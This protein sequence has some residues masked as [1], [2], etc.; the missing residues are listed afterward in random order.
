MSNVKV[1]VGV[2]FCDDEKVR[3]ILVIIVLIEKEE[4]FC[5]LEWI[6]IKLF[7]IIDCIDYIK[8]ILCKN[9]LYLVCEEV[10]CFN[11][12]ECFN[13]GIVIFMILG[14]ICICCCLFC[15]VVYGKLLLLS[16]EEL[17]KL[18]IIIKEMVLKYVVI[19]LVDCDDLCDGGVQYFVDCIKVICEYSLVI[20]IEVLVL[21]FCG[22]MDCVLEIFKDVLLDVFNYNLEII[23]CLYCECCL[24]VNYQWLFDL[25]RKFKVQYFDVLIKFGLMMGMGE[26]QEE[27]VE[28]FKD[29]CVYD[30]EMFILGQY[31]QLSCY[32]FLVK[33]YVYLDEFNVFGDIVKVLGFIYV[34][35]G[36]MVCLSYYVDCQVVGEDVKQFVVVQ[37]E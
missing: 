20:K 13:Y 16:V 35:C 34:V 23:L 4:M 11:L 31:L 18:V 33:C 37:F 14:D 8:Q 6:K 10:S 21:D 22:C 1:K 36:L 15:D 5:K 29:L 28:V 25:F 7:C 2:K 12:V 17:F 9:N 27:I 30:V 3:Y 26:S 24:G 32:Y 19:I